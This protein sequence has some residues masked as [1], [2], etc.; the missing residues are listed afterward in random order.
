M[1]TSTNGARSDTCRVI[2][3]LTGLPHLEYEAY[4][5][6]LTQNTFFD[7]LLDTARVTNRA[8]SR[9][10]ETR[11]ALQEAEQQLGQMDSNLVGVLE[12]IATCLHTN[13]GIVPVR[14]Q[15]G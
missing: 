8:V 11:S 2:R 5:N 1:S 9:L 14:M 10:R 3:R 15:A 7:V 6:A 4:R 12:D 13:R